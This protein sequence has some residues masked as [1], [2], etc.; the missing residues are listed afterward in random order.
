M[1]LN[2]LF[3]SDLQTYVRSLSQYPVK[4]S[5]QT[6]AYNLFTRSSTFS[7]GLTLLVAQMR[8]PQQER[9]RNQRHTETNTGDRQQPLN[10]LIR[11]NH[12]GSDRCSHRIKWNDIQRRRVNRVRKSGITLERQPTLELGIQSLSPDGTGD[13]C[14]EGIAD[15]VQREVQSGDDGDVLVL[16]GR[17]D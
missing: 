11:F 13:A 2:V 6:L 12:R 1:I 14:A 5:D 15:A 17:L 4:N 7:L 16:S 10:M 8:V 9:E 3:L